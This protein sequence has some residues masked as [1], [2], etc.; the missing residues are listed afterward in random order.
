MKV[1]NNNPGNLFTNI[2][3]IT[4]ALAKLDVQEVILD[5]EAQKSKEYKQKV[6]TGKFP[7]LETADGNVF[8]SAAIARY[9][10]RLNPDAGLAG[11]NFTEQA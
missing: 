6:L 3:L 5:A 4:A 1:F 9:F 11:Q 10:A 7:S 8:E 2:A